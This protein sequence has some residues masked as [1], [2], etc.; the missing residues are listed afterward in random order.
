MSCSDDECKLP[1]HSREAN[2]Y[3]KH[4]TYNK[5]RTN[6][7]YAGEIYDA[8]SLL[9]IIL[10]NSREFHSVC[11]TVGIRENFI[12]TNIKKEIPVPSCRADG[13]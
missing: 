9:N 6:D 13:N 5:N 1:P 4:K 10:C 3:P 11:K 8:A 2:T 12:S 7:N